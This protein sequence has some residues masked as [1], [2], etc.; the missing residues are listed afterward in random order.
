MSTLTP[1]KNRRGA[2][3]FIV[4]LMMGVMAGGAILALTQA[5]TSTQ[6]VSVGRQQSRATEV[7]HG[8][9]A[10]A[11]KALPRMLD[12][13][14]VLMDIGAIE[15]GQIFDEQFDVAYFGPDPFA[16]DQSPSCVASIVE[17]Q[18]AISPSGYSQVGGCFKRITLL[19]TGEIAGDG[20]GGEELAQVSTTRE[21]MV[22]GIFGPVGCF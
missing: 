20:N 16:S 21:V 5:R 9:A 19:V 6:V 18:D 14:L 7:A 4:V 8:C 17:I 10:G 13:L 15:V 1:T 3:V 22:R 2:A 11:V 12:S